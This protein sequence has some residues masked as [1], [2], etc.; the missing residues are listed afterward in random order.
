MLLQMKQRLFISLATLYLAHT[1]LRANE[2]CERL[3]GPI[4]SNVSQVQ[5]GNGVAITIHRLSRIP[6]DEASADGI[7]TQSFQIDAADA[8]LRTFGAEIVSKYLS[9]EASEQ[10]RIDEAVTEYHKRYGNAFS[11]FGSRGE[12]ISFM[13]TVSTIPM[14]LKHDDFDRLVESTTPIMQSL[15]SL[16]QIF[17]SGRLTRER[18]TEIQSLL[19]GLN[20]SEARDI[21]ETMASS[22]YF[23]P[24]FRQPQMADYPFLPVA[25][26][27]G[28]IA[29]P[30]SPKPQFFEYN[31][32]TPSGL[33]N[34][35]QLL[36]GVRELDS[37]VFHSMSTR[38][39]Q[40]DSFALLKQSI[41]SAAKTWTGTDDG[42]IV[43]LGPGP[44]NGAH[45][46]IVN[47]ALYSGM[48]YVELQ[49]LYIDRFGDVRLKT[50]GEPHPRVTGIYNRREESY[51]FQDSASGIPLR[52]PYF[53]AQNRE[54]R[55]QH[56]FDVADSIGYD[57]Y[58][59]QNGDVAGVSLDLQGLPKLQKL[60]DPIGV[61]PSLPPDAGRTLANA[62]L[63]KKLY[64]SNLGGR[65]VDDKHL[66]ALLSK[67]LSQNHPSIAAPPSTIASSEVGGFLNES[68]LR[69]YV[70]KEPNK[71]GGEGV[72]ILA[73]LAEEKRREVQAMVAKNP[74][75]FIIQR[76]ANLAS[77]ITA[78]TEGEQV[79]YTPRIVDWGI[80]I[81]QDARGRVASAPQ[82]ILPRVANVSSVSTNTSQGAGYGL[83]VVASTETRATTKFEFSPTPDITVLTQRQADLILRFTQLLCDTLSRKSISLEAIRGLYELSG[84]ITQTLGRD[85]FPMIYELESY[86]DAR[87]DRS[88]F[89]DR[90]AFWERALRNDYPETL[91]IVNVKAR[92]FFIERLSE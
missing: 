77:T 56:K 7:R 64:V 13:P 47:I 73:R 2:S 28:I 84:G 92:Q 67:G 20:E 29:D 3:F 9:R 1:S 19:P 18:S 81:F 78:V 61:D 62:V 44:F 50:A 11:R 54:L 8:S 75:S 16:L 21:Y 90:L 46:D 41:A 24:F 57:V 59:D 38:M 53:D 76:F 45:P 30:N 66:F 43:T 17:Y 87:I 32:G 88:T 14:I 5:L 49:D 68:D 42:I 65:V 10:L 85:F 86:L 72:Y 27:D 80:F 34:L 91:Q 12:K 70:I 69:P 35:R 39:P 33:S 52:N 23:E 6:I 63:Q 83:A 55:E 15:R 25:R 37:N 74:R 71:S 51:L 4:D 60:A 40:D 79:I 26:F 82:A 22:V 48:P 58:F 31:S 89:R 36:E